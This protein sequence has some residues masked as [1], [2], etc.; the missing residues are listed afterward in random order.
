MGLLKWKEAHWSDVEE[1][2]FKS[3]NWEIN[4]W[5]VAV[6]GWFCVVFISCRY[7]ADAKWQKKS[8]FLPFHFFKIIWLLFPIGLECMLGFSE[9][10]DCLSAIGWQRICSGQE[11]VPAVPPLNIVHMCWSYQ[12]WI[13]SATYYQEWISTLMTNVSSTESCYRDQCLFTAVA[14][15][16][17]TAL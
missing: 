6:I 9:Y 16:F 8:V 13:F 15:S 7:S 10:D 11:P 2:T 17:F 14:L 3:Y 4:N 1:D 5:Q 12:E